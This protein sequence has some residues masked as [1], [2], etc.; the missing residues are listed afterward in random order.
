MNRLYVVE[1]CY[2]ITGAMA[3]HRLALRI[4]Q[5]AAFVAALRA[6]SWTKSSPNLAAR[7]SCRS[8]RGAALSCVPL[9]EGLR[10]HRGQTAR[11]VVGPRQPAGVR[12]AKSC[13]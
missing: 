11:F 1:S 8:N 10:A 3:D 6:R 2:T 13:D 9:A 12:S 4:E 7:Q 5:I